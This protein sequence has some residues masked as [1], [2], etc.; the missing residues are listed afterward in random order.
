MLSDGRI[1]WV[2]GLLDARGYFSERPSSH[3]DRRLPT[4]ALTM[5]AVDGEPHPVITWLCERTGVAPIPVKRGGAG[6]TKHACA[7]HC[8]QPH[9]HVNFDYHRW[10]VGGAKATA[11]LRAV[12]P[13]LLMKGDEARRLLGLSAAYKPAHMREMERLGWVPKEG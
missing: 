8:P 7:V 11:V 13:Y 4:V 1:G 3:A 10:I 2:A 9:V 12:E 5:P 6:Y